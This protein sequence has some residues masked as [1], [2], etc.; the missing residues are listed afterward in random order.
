MLYPRLVGQATG[1]HEVVVLFVLL[2]GAEA[3]GIWGALLAVPFTAFAGLVILYAVR[4]WRA[5]LPSPETDAPE[6]IVA[7]AETDRAPAIPAQAAH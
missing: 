4:L 5:G 1:L 3:G 6:P 2:A 7:A